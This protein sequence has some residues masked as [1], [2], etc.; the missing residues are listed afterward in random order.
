MHSPNQQDFASHTQRIRSMHPA[1]LRVQYPVWMLLMFVC[2]LACSHFGHLGA[3]G[4]LDTFSKPS[5]TIG[6]FK[7]MESLVITINYVNSFN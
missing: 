6:A 1:T 7:Q 3:R 4:E 5:Q 2:L